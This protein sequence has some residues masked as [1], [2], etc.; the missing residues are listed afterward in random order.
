MA[1][2]LL[3]TTSAEGLQPLGSPAQRSFEL[4][5]SALRSRLGPDHAALFAEPVASE[6]GE[7]I[8]WHAP[9]AGR[10]ERLIDLAPDAQAALRDLLG[11]LA[12]DIRDEAARLSGT[13]RNDDLRLAEALSNALEV[14]GEE[15]IWSLRDGDRLSP[16][17]V[18]WAW[19]RSERPAVRGVLT[20]MA[21]RPAALPAGAGTGG[22]R[23]PWGWLLILG[24]GGLA[25]LIGAILLVL[26]APCGLD[27][28]GPDFCPAAAPALAAADA[29]ERVL[30]DQIAALE[31]EV[32]LAGRSCQPT[33]P[34]GPAEPRPD[35]RGRAGGGGPRHGALDLGGAD[36]ADL[37]PALPRSGAA[38]RAPRFRAG[39]GRAAT[40][41]R[42]R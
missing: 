2:T 21:A 20:G 34:I 4:V 7:R 6:H 25:M 9:A 32:A 8:D 41:E 28:A 38:G 26:V 29:E 19:K 42:T 10:A 1:G 39:P 24:W 40:T 14:P 16:V 31:R 5:T 36:V 37:R 22:G 11:R 13:G 18:H 35:R 3:I 17:L 30:A 12:T 23:W 27:P 33:I 15:M